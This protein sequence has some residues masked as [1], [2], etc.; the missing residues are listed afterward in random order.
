MAEGL[1]VNIRVIARLSFEGI[2]SWPDAPDQ[3][4]EYYL[5]YPHRHMFH[6][7]AVM[8]VQH[9]DRDVEFIGLRTSMLVYCVRQFSGPHIYS[10][11]KMALELLQQFGLKSCRV[12]EDNENGAE[13]ELR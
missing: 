12:F 8:E 11:E 3:S 4:T 7:E 13:V 2:H 5:A 6:V 1:N 10:C 9:D